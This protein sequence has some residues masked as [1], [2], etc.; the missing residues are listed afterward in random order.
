MLIALSANTVSW[1]TSSTAIA[2][3]IVST[4]VLWR[5]RQ[6]RLTQAKGARRDLARR[7]FAYVSPDQPMP[8]RTVAFINGTDEPLSDCYVFYTWSRSGEEPRLDEFPLGTIPPHDRATFTL[9]MKQP[10]RWSPRGVQFKDATGVVW[11]RHG[12]DEP[13]QQWPKEKGRKAST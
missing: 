7:V 1:I 10:I 5:D 4:V 11:T 9:P 2:A 8:Y 6:L 12:M 13:V 3:V